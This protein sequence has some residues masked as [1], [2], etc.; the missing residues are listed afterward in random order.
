MT[1][2]SRPDRQPTD[3]AGSG[4]SDDNA[5]LGNRSAMRG[6]EPIDRDQP[7][8][9]PLVPACSSSAGQSSARTEDQHAERDTPRPATNGTRRAGRRDRTDLAL[10]EAAGSQTLQTGIAD[11]DS[12]ADDRA[13][14]EGRAGV[15]TRRRGWFWH[16]NN[17][18]TQYAPLIG[19]KGVGLLNSYTVW[20]DRRDESPHRGYAFPSQQSEADFY[21]E[22]R[23]ELITINKILVALDL[24]EIRKEMITR[25]DERGRRW[26]VPHNLYRVKDR[27]DGV[28]LR[29]L[30][31]LRVAEL[32][33][34]DAAVFRYVRRVFSDRFKPIDGDNVW[35]AILTDLRND[36][37][38]RE[39]QERT[40]AIE[41]RASARTRAGH[42]N[43]TNA[44]N[45]KSP[46]APA[47]E[48]TDS[49]VEPA[50][51]SGNIDL[52]PHT[53]HEDITMTKPA[54]SVER[55]NSGLHVP[56][57]TNVDRFNTGLAMDVAR[58]NGAFTSS[59]PTIVAAGS[60][61]RQPVVGTGN[62]T[63][64]QTDL[65]T[66][67]TTTSLLKSGAVMGG[68]GHVLL[69]TQRPASTSRI[70]KVIESERRG[71]PD[72]GVESDRGRRVA[73]GELA[74]GQPVDER[75]EGE[76]DER[77]PAG[78]RTGEIA[79][80]RS[81][82]DPDAGGPLVDPGRL[83]VSTFEDANDRRT[84]PLERSLLAELE[85]DADPAARAVGSTGAS[86]IV[87]AMRE[88][89]S[90]GSAFVAPKRIREIVTRWSA[91]PRNAPSA[92]AAVAAAGDQAPNPAIAPTGPA[93]DVR[94]PGGA[95]GDAIWE[96]TLA[97]LARVFDRDTYDR[98]LAGSR[99]TRYWRGTVEIT[100]ASS[101]A[102]DKL[103]NEYRSLVERHLNSRLRRPVAVRFDP[104][105]VVPPVSVPVAEPNEPVAAETPQPLVVV[106]SEAE[107]GR[108]V[109]Q[110]LMS[111]LARVVSPSD[112]D[113]LAGVIVLGQDASGAILLGAPSPLATRLI[114]R[115]YRAEVESSLA[116]LLGHPA[117]IRI[118]DSDDWHVDSRD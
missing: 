14:S 43:R 10:D 48:L 60:N 82:A 11:P 21:G 94:L 86:W 104:H 23:A 100:V 22:E 45:T 4:A 20:T 13:T 58:T 57:E 78:A 41:A 2:Q 107:I 33:K 95:S 110:S 68:G 112:L 17:V 108:Q 53:Q 42:Q 114:D 12:S 34:R 7:G 28:D 16:W 46:S 115:R 98:L 25:V 49:D 5:P 66:T 109:W 52:L 19:L 24:I 118:L 75:I 36:Q 102:A 105:P 96:A 79:G 1:T 37:T 80:E 3:A 26:R 93:E 18:V 81:L 65:T 74:V 27:P 55:T 44:S 38:W 63:Y 69:E 40:R 8:S 56:D 90:S 29:A 103:S 47:A 6:S 117:P 39:L 87:A 77:Q 113:R 106:E 15:D 89:V 85:R 70:G 35:H 116:A 61:G 83:V 99:I 9:I 54:T 71:G 62:T 111:D 88:A 101:T 32:A 73:S 91:D 92:P 76:S 84:T 59:D 31:V 50:I 72:E 67:T 64:D 51:A 97:D 30:D